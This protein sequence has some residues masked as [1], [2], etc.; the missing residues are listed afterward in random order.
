MPP[1]RSI[2]CRDGGFFFD[3]ARFFVAFLC[4]AEDG[5]HPLAWSETDLPGAV[6][7][8]FDEMIEINL[9]QGGD[10]VF[11]VGN[12]LERFGNLVLLTRYQWSA[13]L[14]TEESRF[15]VCI[16]KK[17]DGYPAIT[18]NATMMAMP[19]SD[20]AIRAANRILLLVFF[21]ISLVLF[22]FSI[23]DIGFPVRGS[24]CPA[25]PWFRKPGEGH[26]SETA[27]LQ[28]S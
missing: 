2:F 9:S 19:A 6:D 13:P 5:I 1:P 4:H 17:T 3:L 12:E 8:I 11:T 20:A 24:A 23:D 14:R 22:G 27:L 21:M 26:D 7:D 18:F 28:C 10:V 16:A 25:D 15:L